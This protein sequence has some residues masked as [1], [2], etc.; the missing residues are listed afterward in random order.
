MSDIATQWRELDQLVRSTAHAVEC[1]YAVLY[2]GCGEG[3]RVAGSFGAATSLSL[4]GFDLERMAATASGNEGQLVINDARVDQR[5]HAGEPD[6]KAASIAPRFLL[7]LS[8]PAEDGGQEAVLFIAD[9]VAHAGITPAQHYVLRTLACAIA[10]QLREPA[11]AAGQAGR[12]M[13]SERLRLLESVVINAKDAVLITE[14]EP[15]DN[16]GPRIVYCN[17]AFTRTTGYRED[18]VIGKTPRLLQSPNTDREALNRLRAALEK[19]QPVEVELLNVRK[20]G[21]EFWVELSIVPVCDETGWYTHWISVQRDVSE[22]RL[23]EL[24]ARRAL[25]AEAEK[26][27]LEAQLEERKR[28]EAELT[29]MATHDDLT[30]LRNRAFFMD[31]LRIVIER[32]RSGRGG[33]G[34]LPFVFFMD[35]DRFKLVNDSLGHRAGDLL[36]IGVA[37]RLLQCLRPEDTLARMGGDEFV[38]LVESA[39]GMHAAAALAERLIDALKPPLRVEGH[40]VFPM[41]SIG[42]VQVAAH[43]QSAEE[44]V[45]DAD[46]AMYEAKSS[47]HSRYQ[48]F[49]GGMREGAVD[50]L[51]LQTDLQHAIARNEFVL[52]YQLVHDTFT[53]RIRGAEALIRWQHPQMGMVPPARFIPIAEDI[54]LIK[55]IGWWVLRTALAQMVE[56]EREHPGVLPR[57]NVNVSA[58]EL[59][60]NGFVERLE[61]A[62]AQ[63]GIDPARLQLEITEGV[64]LQDSAATEGVLR[65]IRELGVRVALDDFGTGYSSL[66]YLDKYPVDS[67][68]VDRSFVVRMLTHRRTMAI[69]KSIIRLGEALHVDIVAE[70]VE[71][72]EQ[73]GQLSDMRCSLAQ[74]YLLSRPMPAA[75]IAQ[76][77][78]AAAENTRSLR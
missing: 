6:P 25:L 15:I 63:A 37:A 53:G 64:F 65:R 4:D 23:S 50:A 16:P 32:V 7:A 31:R 77:L 47:P 75:D 12:S 38:V 72:A 34:G 9:F 36:L 49:T 13:L 44:V 39:D 62:V 42:I 58:V 61:S 40:D 21:T 20:D 45:R 76:Q 73:L 46:V 48:L 43:Y 52:H 33:R 51:R 26:R 71:T 10:R 74:G 29:Y 54:G 68:K 56:W 60:G 22:R 8:I 67:I 14:A 2:A 24:N 11:A 41:C 78:H 57:L 70:G 27:A 69:V 3:Q 5:F 30:K 1:P 55:D 35:L 28:I 19:W 59:L 66:A 17:A 18:E